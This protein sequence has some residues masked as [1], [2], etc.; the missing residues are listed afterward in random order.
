M[1]SER[2]WGS[3]G[4]R[5]GRGW[6]SGCWGWAPCVCSMRG[7]CA[8]GW[9]VIPEAPSASGSTA[10]TY[11]QPT[12]VIMIGSAMIAI[13]ALFVVRQMVPRFEHQRSDP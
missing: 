11:D 12:T 13:N 5:F 9:I 7:R 1:E 4:G 3:S 6:A 2:N 10:P 8:V